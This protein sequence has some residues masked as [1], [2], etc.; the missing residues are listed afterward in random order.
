MQQ[1]PAIIAQIDDDPPQ[2]RLLCLQLSECIFDIPGRI[3]RKRRQVNIPDTVRYHAIVRNIQYIYISPH[4]SDI[5]IARC[6]RAANSQHHLRPR[7]SPHHLIEFFHRLI[8]GIAS[9]DCDN[10]I[11]RPQP[12]LIGWLILV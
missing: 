12:R 6:S 8:A 4:Q 5:E 10:L 3:R 11:P 9:I 7:E 2:C 1:A